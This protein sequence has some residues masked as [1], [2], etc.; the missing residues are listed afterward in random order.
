METNICS[1]A[2]THCDQIT[3]FW[4]R[5]LRQEMSCV[6]VSNR[7]NLIYI[8]DMFEK[9]RAREELKNLIMI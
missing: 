8:L 9:N 4:G 3:H 7:G 6:I 1:L 2:D 5:I